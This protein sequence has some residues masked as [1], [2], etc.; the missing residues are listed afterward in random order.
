MVGPTVNKEMLLKLK[1]GEGGWG[2]PRERFGPP[3]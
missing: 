2:G 1:G 3:G